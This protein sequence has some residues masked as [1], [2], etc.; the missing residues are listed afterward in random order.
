MK[1][2]NK[3]LIKNT[4]LFAL[5]NF[6]SKLISFF[7]LPLYTN[8]LTAAE[9]GTIDLLLIIGMIL[10]PILT[11]NI[12]EAVMRFLLD[13]DLKEYEILNISYFIIFLFFILSIILVPIFSLFDVIANY[14]YLFALYVFTLGTSTILMAYIRG[15][16]KVLDYS[17]IGI[18]QTFMIALLNIVFLLVFNIGIEGYILAYIL[19]YFITIVLCV[20]RGDLFKKSKFKRFNVVLLKSMTK[21]SLFLIPNSIMWWIINSLDRIMITSMIGISANGIYAVSYKIPSILSTVTSVFN[22]AWTYS[23]IKEKDSVDKNEYTNEVYKF[24]FKTMIII[25]AS[26]TLIIKPF[27]RF[28][29]GFEFYSAW[30][31][32]PPLILGTVFLTASSFLANEYTVHK[33]SKGFFISSSIGAFVNVILNYFLINKIGILGAAIATCLCYISIYL[34]RVI[35]TKKYV[36][37]TYFDRGIIFS[38]SIYI[39]LSFILYFDNLLSYLFILLFYLVILLI[40]KDILV[41]IFRLFFRMTKKIERK[42]YNEK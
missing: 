26:L 7:L 5:G 32:I 28:Y 4:F 8:I 38:L 22:Q 24:L 35:D 34:Y 13:K 25:A 27:L 30:R 12:S 15:I 11:L 42:G 19:S 29:V 36:K 23:A 39:L 9:Y 3:Y 20:V 40:N 10:V 2:R 14:T 41:M 18:I 16:E 17:I 37:I 33:D 21:Y 31:F 1:K 6:G